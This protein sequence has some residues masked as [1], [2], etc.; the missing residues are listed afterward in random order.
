MKF[1]DYIR[2]F[3]RGKEARLIEHEAMSDPFLADAIDGYDSVNGNHAD[4]IAQMQ[5]RISSRSV[6]KKK[7]VAWRV[8]VAAA[9]FIAFLGGYFALMNHESAMLV[10]HEQDNS[11]INLYAP[12]SYIEQKS[13]ELTEKEE[14]GLVEEVR[15]TAVVD[16]T[17]LDEVI[18]PIDRIEIYLPKDYV[19]KPQPTQ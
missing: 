17:N 12:E 7:S 1:L 5:A 18:K 4:H 11:F 16:I 3:R 19:S 13:L 15:I 6:S 14:I 8:T 9:V 2:G 10:A